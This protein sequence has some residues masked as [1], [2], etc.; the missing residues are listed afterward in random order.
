MSIYAHR[1]WEKSI[2]ISIRFW[3]RILREDPQGVVVLT[4]DKLSG[5]ISNQLRGRFAAHMPDVASRIVFMP[6]LANPDYL[7]LT[8]V[9]D[10]LL[11]PLHYG[12]VNASYDGFSLNKPIVTLPSQFHRGRYTSACYRKMGISDCVATDARQYVQIAVALGTDRAFRVDVEEK[13]R[14]ASHLLF[15]DV[16]AV[17]EHERIFSELIE[18]ARSPKG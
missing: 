1:S 10:L 17:S 4:E 8:V 15:E 9:A 18:E 13:I 3:R 6:F 11:D 7:N 5:P 2:R 12:G 14:A 16:E